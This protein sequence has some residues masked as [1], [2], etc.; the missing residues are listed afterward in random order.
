MLTLFTFS[1]LNPYLFFLAQYLSCKVL[2]PRYSSFI[3]VSYWRASLSW[4]VDFSVTNLFLLTLSLPLLSSSSTPKLI[5][6][7]ILSQYLQLS[8]WNSPSLI[9][10]SPLIFVDVHHLFGDLIYTLPELCPFFHVLVCGPNKSTWSSIPRIFF[11]CLYYH[12]RV[13]LQQFH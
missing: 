8:P 4:P 10:I 12:S 9:S 5:Q 1:Q 13:S 3:S 6:F 2:Y 7:H 11:A